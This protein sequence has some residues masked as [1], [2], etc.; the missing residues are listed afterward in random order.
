MHTSNMDRL[1]SQ[2]SSLIAVCHGCAGFARHVLEAFNMRAREMDDPVNRLAL[3]LNPCYKL[4]ADPTGARFSEMATTVS[5]R[6][7]R[8]SA[9]VQACT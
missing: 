2:L 9:C 8:V 6:A 5:M 4:V 1:C 3:W 7:L